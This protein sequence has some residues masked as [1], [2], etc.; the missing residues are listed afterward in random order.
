MALPVARS[1][2]VSDLHNL[3]LSRTNASKSNVFEMERTGEAG[4]ERQKRERE[5]ERER[6][7]E[8]LAAGKTAD[9]AVLLYDI[10][11]CSPELHCM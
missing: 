9:T 5:R 8:F 3:S 1:V 10:T 4:I 2:T 11:G 7:G 6:E